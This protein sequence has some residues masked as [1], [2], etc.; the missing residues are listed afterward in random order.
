MT[1][2]RRPLLALMT[3]GARWVGQDAFPGSE[4]A[5]DGIEEWLRFI[6]STGRLGHYLPRLRDRAAVRDEALAEIQ[7]AYFLDRQGHPV[8][9]WDPPKGPRGVCE[10]CVAVA[11]AVP[12]MAVEVKAPG[13]EADITADVLRS[14]PN[15]RK[16]PKYKACVESRWTG[17]WERVRKAVEDACEQLPATIPT[18]L[19]INDDLVLNLN[20][21]PI[22]VV[23]GT[24]YERRSG[25]PGCFADATFDG[26]GAVGILN[27][28]YRNIGATFTFRLYENPLCRPEVRLPESVLPGYR[29]RTPAI[30]PPSTGWEVIRGLKPPVPQIVL[31]D[32][33]DDEFFP[34][35]FRTYED[36]TRLSPKDL[37]AIAPAY[38][39]G[40]REKL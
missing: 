39:A 22:D 4:L 29:Q 13:W 1:L 11:G 34:W 2:I 9:T 10:F 28:E 18:L 37:D 38:R 19:V 15:R 6:E 21:F 33:L 3:N 27:I 32:G 5:A 23:W 30:G 7:A 24:L 16:Q 31:S 20:R 17:P 12:T 36:P 14:E 35:L 25:R 26:L 8:V 40:R